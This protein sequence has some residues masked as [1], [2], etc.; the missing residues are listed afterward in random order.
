MIKVQLLQS[1]NEV[2]A[3]LAASIVAAA[4]GF[5]GFMA[6]IPCVA[7]QAS[8]KPASFGAPMIIGSE[9]VTAA[10]TN[11]SL[12]VPVKPSAIVEQQGVLSQKDIVRVLPTAPGSQM[13]E[14]SQM[15]MGNTIELAKERALAGAS[16]MG[17]VGA[18]VSSVTNIAGGIVSGLGG[19]IGILQIGKGDNNNQEELSAEEKHAI[20]HSFSLEVMSATQ[21][22]VGYRGLINCEV[23]YSAQDQAL[24]VKVVEPLDGLAHNAQLVVQHNSRPNSGAS[25]SHLMMRLDF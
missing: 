9:K 2:Q 11:P 20:H 23:T 7:G 5:L 8:R 21:A 19:G 15:M 12:N 13:L 25:S 4:L 22:K 18:A 24:D 17:F 6:C 16:K 14:V 3:Q 1:K 10:L